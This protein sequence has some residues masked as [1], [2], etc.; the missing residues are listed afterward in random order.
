M[1]KNKCIE[2]FLSLFSIQVY[3]RSYEKFCFAS[4]GLDAG[5]FII[6]T[7]LDGGGTD[8]TIPEHLKKKVVYMFY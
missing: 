5:I 4:E 8:I 6:V 7:N 2:K 3:K 1:I